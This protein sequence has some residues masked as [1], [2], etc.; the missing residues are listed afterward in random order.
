MTDFKLLVKRIR[1]NIVLLAAIKTNFNK[2]KAY[3]IVVVKLTDE[4]NMLLIIF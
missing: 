1:N 2:L 4:F 3:I